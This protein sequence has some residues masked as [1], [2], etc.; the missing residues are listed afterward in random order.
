MGIAWRNAGRSARVRAA[1][2]AAGAGLVLA[3]CSAP[4]A[5]T[6]AG[7]PVPAGRP[8]AGSPSGIVSLTAISVLRSLFNRADG[9]TR[10]VLIFSP[11]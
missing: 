3:S 2:A 7:T 5:S 8:G 6:A 1:V 4:A 9:H 10:L 11:T